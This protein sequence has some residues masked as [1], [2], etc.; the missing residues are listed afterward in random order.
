[1]AL[2]VELDAVHDAGTHAI[3]Y[4]EASTVLQA[5]RVAYA[6]VSSN[7]SRTF[8]R[9]SSVTLPALITLSLII[10]PAWEL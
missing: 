4:T 10:T 1:M 9:L 7:F 8:L 2:G 6:K 3:L 5:R